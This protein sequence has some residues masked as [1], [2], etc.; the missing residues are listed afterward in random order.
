[1]LAWELRAARRLLNSS[2]V[3]VP[4]ARTAGFLFLGGLWAFPIVCCSS[5]FPRRLFDFFAGTRVV[6]PRARAR[7]PSSV[8]EVFSGTEIDR[9]P[10][11]LLPGGDAPGLFGL[12]P[13]NL[14]SRCCVFLYSFL[15]C[16]RPRPPCIRRCSRLGT[17]GARPPFPCPSRTQECDIFPLFVDGSFGIGSAHAHILFFGWAG[18]LPLQAVWGSSEFLVCCF[19]SLV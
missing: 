2:F 1:L 17:F 6:S 9:F 8:F 14:R 5:F 12:R 3:S 4:L 19:S 7:V 13:L 18:N 16:S 10:F 11:A 15:C